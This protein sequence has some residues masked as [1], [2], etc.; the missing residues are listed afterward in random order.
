MYKL[1][2]KSMNSLDTGAWETVNVYPDNEVRA[3][4]LYEQ[5]AQVYKFVTLRREDTTTVITPLR[6]STQEAQQ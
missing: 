3:N 5:Y 2:F 4:E 6:D 1:I